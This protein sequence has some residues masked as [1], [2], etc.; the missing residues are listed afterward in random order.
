[1][2]RKLEAKVGLDEQESDIR[3]FARG[4][5]AMYVIS[6]ILIRTPRQ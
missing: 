2:G 1:V 6:P 4:K 3:L 5:A